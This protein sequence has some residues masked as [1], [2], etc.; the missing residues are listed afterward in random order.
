MIRPPLKIKLK[1][2]SV[3]SETPS[4]TGYLYI[5]QRKLEKMGIDTRK[6]IIAVDENNKQ[7]HCFMNYYDNSLYV[8]TNTLYLYF[9]P[10]PLVKE[11]T[12][13]FTSKEFEI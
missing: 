2:K 8:K 9:H 6:L 4:A 13:F 7:V 10:L 12:A 3:S 1:K 11:K 5:P